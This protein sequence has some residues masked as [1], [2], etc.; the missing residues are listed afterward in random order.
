LSFD[1]TGELLNRPFLDFDLHAVS[2]NEWAI[3]VRAL[4]RRYR[5]DRLPV[6]NGGLRYSNLLEGPAQ[7]FTCSPYRLWEYSSLFL[8]LD[9]SSKGDLLLDLGGAGAPLAY[10][11]AEYGYRV[12]T[13]DLQPMLVAAARHVAAARSLPIEARVA[14][15]TSDLAELDGT[16]GTVAFISVLE[17]VPRVARR[18]V[19]AAI[20]RVLRSGGLLYMT[21]D[22]GDY[23]EVDSYE[24]RGHAE[25]ISRSIDDVVS[26]SD[27]LEQIGFRFRGNDPRLLPKSMLGARKSPG[28]KRVLRNLAMTSDPFDGDTPWIEVAKYVVKRLVGHTPRGVSRFDRHNFFRMYLEKR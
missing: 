21:F 18:D 23:E 14:D 7:A 6:M 9:A 19:L 13:V 25:V 11:A 4:V 20:F 12:M 22:Y 3:R 2:T 27:E 24:Q 26:L 5:D 17:H 15:I 10:V 1:A 28:A 8:G 16:V